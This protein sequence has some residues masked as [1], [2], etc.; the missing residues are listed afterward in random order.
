LIVG[1]II[2]QNVMNWLV[3][4]IATLVNPSAIVERYRHEHN[5]HWM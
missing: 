1:L 3:G 5:L 2:V 4:L